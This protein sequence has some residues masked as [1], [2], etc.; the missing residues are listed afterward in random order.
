MQAPIFDFKSG[1][2]SGD[3]VELDPE[4]YNLP[5]RRDIVKNVF[6]YWNK[7]DRYILK[8]TKDF[9]MVAGSGIKPV[10][11]KGRGAA[12][13]GNK[14]AP[15]RKGGGVSHGP[16]PR[17]LGYP[18]NHKVRL[19]AIKTLLSAKLFEDRVVFIDSEAIEYPKTQYLNAI[20]EPYGHDKLCF[21]AGESVDA[22]FVQAS[23]NIKNLKIRAP[24]EFNVPDLLMADYIF[25]TR[26]GLQELETILEQRQSNYFRNRKV[27]TPERIEAIKQKRMNPYERDIMLPILESEFEDKP[28]ELQSPT[29]K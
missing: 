12:R 17:C 24:Q 15:Q 6:D 23:G 25:M 10:P 21:V 4:I 29:L 18:I 26:Q 19:L 13:Q 27:S 11:Q 22:N 9:G 8:K 2:F 14:R 3:M 1:D 28:L 16:V 5:L 20:V 7:K